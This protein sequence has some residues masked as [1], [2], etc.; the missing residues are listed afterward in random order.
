MEILELLI[1]Y[2]QADEETRNLLDEVVG[3]SQE[4]S[5]DVRD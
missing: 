2:L 3:V 5:S 1:A 4:Q